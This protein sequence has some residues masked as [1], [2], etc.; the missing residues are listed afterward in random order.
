M[1]GAF[2]ESI[3]EN[4][5]LSWLG[6]LGYAIGHGPHMAALI[7][8]I[9]VNRTQSRTLC[10]LHDTLLSKLLSG[11]LNRVRKRKIEAVCHLISAPVAE[12]NT[13]SNR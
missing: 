5:T 4:T 12:S 1:T 10:S 8:Q 3:V 11:E 2:T 7:D 13:H 6:E 9:I